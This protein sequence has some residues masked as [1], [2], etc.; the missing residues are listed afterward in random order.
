MKRIAIALACAA[1]LA[2]GCGKESGEPKA[3]E[4]APTKAPESAPKA[5]ETASP[6]PAPAA[7]DFTKEAQGLMDR[8]AAALNAKD[9]PGAETAL[10]SLEGLRSKLPADW[11]KKIDDLAGTVKTAKGAGSLLP[12]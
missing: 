9:I 4:S 6:P 2:A 1:F 12:R 5:P 8:V 3:P 11:Q 7:A 10:E